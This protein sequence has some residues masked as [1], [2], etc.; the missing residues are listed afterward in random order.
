VQAYHVDGGRS[1]LEL[2]EPPLLSKPLKLPDRPSIAVLPF[3][4]MSGDP[5]QEYLVDGIVDELITY[6]YRAKWLLVIARGSSFAYKGRSVDIKQ[7]GRELGVRYVLEGSVRKSGNRIRVTV[8]LAEATTGSHVWSDRFDDALDDIFDLQDRIAESVTGAI[9]P[10]IR[11]AEVERARAKPTES[12]DAYDLY[13][14]ALPLHYSNQRERLREAQHLLRR[15]IELDP[16]YSRAK[17]FS[18]L[19]TVIQ[20]NQG[21]T[22][23]EERQEGVRLAR[24]ALAEHYDDPV[25]LRCAGHALGYLA[26]DHEVAIALLERALE[27]NPSSAEVRHSAGWVYTFGYEGSKAAEHFR[28][29]IRLSPLDREMGHSLMGLCFAQLIM[30]QYRE[31]LETSKRAMA[32]MP[33]S[34]SPLRAGIVACVELDLRD[35]ALKLGRAILAINPDF[36]LAEF[37]KI[38]PFKDEAFVKRFLDALRTAGLPE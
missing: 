12:L 35:E 13:L 32:A 11:S 27:L 24:E 1:G 17:A 37:R 18:A 8:Q 31:A 29:A 15:A 6:L 14:R 2:D 10:T 4:N 28:R 3:T 20:T 5:E 23:L 25:T 9:E 38:Q 30:G 16:A 26:H 19:T 36:R 21:W 33:T 7:V 22:D 34:L